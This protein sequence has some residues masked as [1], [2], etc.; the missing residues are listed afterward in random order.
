MTVEMIY[1]EDET[2]FQADGTVFARFD[3]QHDQLAY[4][5]CDGFVA[6]GVT[7]IQDAEQPT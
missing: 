7:V 4:R 2:W 5:L 3:R 6:G 1:A